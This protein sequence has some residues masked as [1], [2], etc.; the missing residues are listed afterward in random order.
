MEKPLKAYYIITAKVHDFEKLKLYGEKA[1]ALKKKYGGKTI[2]SDK[3]PENLEG[4]VQGNLNVVIEFPSKEKAIAWY[5]DNDYAEAK[6]IR[7]AA[8]DTV[9]FLLVTGKKI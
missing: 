7:L 5:N 9:S 6:K 4:E 2:I 8:S 3:N 1:A